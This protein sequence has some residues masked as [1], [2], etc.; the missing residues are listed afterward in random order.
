M[1]GENVVVVRPRASS[2]GYINPDNPMARLVQGS[3]GGTVEVSIID[4][5]SLRADNTY[6][7]VFRDTLILSGNPNVPDTIKTKDFSLLNI[8]AGRI[9]TLIKTLVD[10][11][12]RAI[13]AA[14]FP[15]H[16][17]K[18]WEV[19]A[20]NPALSGWRTDRNVNIATF[21][22]RCSEI[23]PSDCKS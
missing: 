16:R 14:G 5:D 1:T 23:R 9:D 10:T 12:A 18:C 3:A 6:R 8:S 7:V 17:E 13:R 21:V 4:P 2:A 11:T 19:T 15:R 22:S 20:Y